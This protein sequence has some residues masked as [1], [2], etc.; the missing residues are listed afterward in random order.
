MEQRIEIPII[1]NTFEEKEAI[2]EIVVHETTG[3]RKSSSSSSSSD[4]EDEKE[5]KPDPKTENILKVSKV[6]TLLKPFLLS[7]L[8]SD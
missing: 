7:I 1:E 4:S 3:S 2:P 6:T 5:R 8:M